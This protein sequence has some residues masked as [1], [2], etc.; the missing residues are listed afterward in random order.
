MMGGDITADSTADVGSTFTVT[1][2]FQVVIEAPK[3]LIESGT[4]DERG[5]HRT[6][7][8]GDVAVGTETILVIDDDPAVHDLLQR[9]LSRAGYR[10]IVA[11]SGQEGLARA[12]AEH[13]D[14]ITLDIMMPGMDGWS[15]LTALKSDPVLKDI[16]VFVLTMTSEKSLGYALG[17]AQFL[18]K[19]VNREALLGLLRQYAR[20]PTSCRVLVI[21]DD[22]DNR[23]L[24]RRVLESESIEAFEATDG[25]AGL[26]WLAAHPLPDLVILDLMMPNMDGFSFV[27]AL[28]N[29]PE[30]DRLPVVVLTAKT[31]TDE[32]RQRLSLRVEHIIERNGQSEEDVI[33]RLHEQICA[34]REKRV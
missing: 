14:F 26:D 30:F 34:Q 22:A 9:S 18:T 1:L 28:R 23:D 2:P 5:E 12:R 32:D 17:A 10:V 21:D 24:M 27:D 15:V 31:L 7:A 11:G 16:P 20:H 4:V 33:A 29:K 25:Q 19:P 6:D 8:A 13:P 3:P